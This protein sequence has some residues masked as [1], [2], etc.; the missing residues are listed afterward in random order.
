MILFTY[1][2]PKV[3]LIAPTSLTSPPVRPAN[4]D[5]NMWLRFHFHLT[6]GMKALSHGLL[7]FQKPENPSLTYSTPKDSALKATL[8]HPLT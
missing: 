4:T 2:V 3:L 8:F 7:Q 5:E 1:I 6:F